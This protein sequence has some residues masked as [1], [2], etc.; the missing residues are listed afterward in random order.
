MKTDQLT[1]I[2]SIK[3]KLI[4]P[5]KFN[6]RIDLIFHVKHFSKNQPAGFFEKLFW[7]FCFSLEANSND[8]SLAML[9]MILY[10]GSSIVSCQFHVVKSGVV[11]SKHNEY[12][13]YN[14]L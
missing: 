6:K 1:N 8:W 4:T 13:I 5:V 7:C 10:Y 14:G 11:I 12:E 3:N 2:K 9:C